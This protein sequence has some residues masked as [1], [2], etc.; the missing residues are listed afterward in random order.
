VPFVNAPDLTEL[1][2]NNDNARAAAGGAPANTAKVATATATAAFVFA[3]VYSGLSI[4]TPGASA[5]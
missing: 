1:I 4:I 3:T 5:S 2:A